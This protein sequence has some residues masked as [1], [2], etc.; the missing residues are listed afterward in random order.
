MCRRASSGAETFGLGWEGLEIR[1]PDF[2]VYPVS[3]G[4]RL[5]G[6]GMSAGRYCAGGLVTAVGLFNAGLRQR[7]G[8]WLGWIE[9]RRENPSLA[10]GARWVRWSVLEV[11]R[12]MG[13]CKGERLKPVCVRPLEGALF[14]LSGA[15]PG[16]QR[17]A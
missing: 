9:W 11:V 12:R 15:V 1:P 8:V 6:T 14:I 16:V 2:S 4:A 13:R 7:L 3:R 17:L 10:V 5:G